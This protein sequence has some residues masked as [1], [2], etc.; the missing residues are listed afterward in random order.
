MAVLNPYIRIISRQRHL[1]G[2]ILHEN[3]GMGLTVD[4]HNLALVV[5][6]ILDALHRGDHLPRGS[7]VVELTTGQ[8]QNGDFQLSQF[9]VGNSRISTERT[10]EL[11]I[12]V[13]FLDTVPFTASGHQQPHGLVAQ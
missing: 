10:T 3:R 11:R 7:E 5:Y 13:I 2:R 1:Y 9:V 8:W 12:E 6:Q 4:V